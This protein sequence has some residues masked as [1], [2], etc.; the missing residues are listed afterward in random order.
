MGRDSDPADPRILTD[1]TA[2]DFRQLGEKYLSDT[3]ICRLDRASFIDKMPNNF[4]DIGLIHLMLANTRIIDA[5][6][7]NISCCFSNF[8]QLF[9]NGQEFS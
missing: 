9:A 8:K 3:R 5:R 2:D 6:R 4:S 7:E 1:M